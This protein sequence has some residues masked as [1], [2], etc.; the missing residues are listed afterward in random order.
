VYLARGLKEARRIALKHK[1][2]DYELVLSFEVKILFL[3]F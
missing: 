2:D 1:L 3:F